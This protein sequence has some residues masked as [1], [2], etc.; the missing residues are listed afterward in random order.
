MPKKIFDGMSKMDIMVL[1]SGGITSGKFLIENQD[2]YNYK[3]VA[4]MTNKHTSKVFDFDGKIPIIYSSLKNFKLLWGWNPNKFKKGTPELK[5]Y[6]KLYK[7]EMRNEYDEYG[8]NQVMNEIM[9]KRINI[10][11]GFLSGYM[12]K[13][14]PPLLNFFDG[15][16]FN[17]HP[18]NLNILDEK[19]KPKYVGDDTVYDAI[20]DGEKATYSSIHI[21]T[22][23]VDEGPVVV[24]SKPLEVKIYDQLQNYPNAFPREFRGYTK[25]EIVRMYV[26]GVDKKNP[27]S[28]LFYKTLGLDPR[29]HQEIQKFDCDNPATLKAIEL[30]SLGE[31]ETETI[32]GKLTLVN[33]IYQL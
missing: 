4:L 3:V 6:M 8:Y 23:K 2:K 20:L 33:D 30:V 31:L 27:V 24:I 17:V 29:G 13:I 21:V 10:D 14:Y 26:D 22:E 32:D 5:Q 7:D 25:E 12:L 18:A 9:N 1:G 15:A 11:G 28:L 19:G 16:L